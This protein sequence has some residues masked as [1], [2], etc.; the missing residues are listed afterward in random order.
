MYDKNAPVTCSTRLF[1]ICMVLGLLAVPFS[2]ACTWAVTPIVH[3][4][5]ATLSQSNS[6]DI[7]ALMQ[8]FLMS[9]MANTDDIS[10]A[11]S[12]G[13]FSQAWVNYLKMNQ[14]FGQYQSLLQQFNISQADYNAILSNMNLTDDQVRTIINNSQ[15]FQNSSMLYNTSLENGDE[16]NVSLYGSSI[17]NS[18]SNISSSYEAFRNNATA[19]E[20]ILGGRGM[21]TT[22]LNN[23]LNN[24]NGYL[25]NITSTYRDLGFG[26]NNAT[27][28]LNASKDLVS[29]G[30]SVQFTVYLTD[31]NNTPMSGSAVSLYL[32]GLP[33]G[34]VQTGA[35]GEGLL[36]CTIPANVSSDNI[37]A[38]AQYIPTTGAVSPA[39]SNIV[40]LNVTGMNT[41]LKLAM[42]PEIISYQAGAVVRGSLASVGGIPAPGK[43]IGFDIDGRYIG[44]ATTDDN[45][46]YAYSLAIDPG[47][48]AGQHIF[49]A[50]Y[51]PGPG[52][53]FL[54]SSGTKG[55][56]VT[57]LDTSLTLTPGSH[58]YSLCDQANVS[59]S[60]LTMGGTPVKGVNVSVLIDNITAGVFTTNDK[61][62]YAGSFAIPYDIAPGSHS[63]YAVF[64]PS[65][66]G[67]LFAS[68]AGPVFVNISDSG[69]MLIVSG[70]PPLLFRGEPLNLTG[71]MMTGKGVPVG[72]ENLSISLDGHPYMTV[73]TDSAGD[74]EMNAST[75]NAGPGIYTLTISDAGSGIVLY[76]GNAFLS[77]LSRFGT[78]GFV[79]LILVILAAIT[80]IIAMRFRRKREAAIIPVAI[81]PDAF[82]APSPEPLPEPFDLE[83]ELARIKAHALTGDL[84]AA[85]TGAYTAAKKIV[86]L[87][88]V[89]VRDWMTYFEFYSLAATELPSVSMPLRHIVNE[90]EKAVYSGEEVTIA[91]FDDTL[92]DL[93]RISRALG[94]EKR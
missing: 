63:F 21:D 7:N 17:V 41:I 15:L 88:G 3:V 48:T 18:Y 35:G 1:I 45:G 40:Y 83:K 69:H 64:R 27:L 59:G 50:V 10:S 19:L 67:S 90:Y 24:F 76:S 53:V 73:T 87:K 58:N 30:D 9:I 77:P 72:G 68:T 89:D 44:N 6:V 29:V 61:G 12:A 74:F 2:A 13:N 52:Q 31:Q 20:Q 43:T 4:D 80:A 46:M 34:S 28:Q 93:M 11:V 22:H 51:A 49:N 57:P 23:S 47:V 5:P 92:E 75:D 42:S 79:I 66:G 78:I 85:F 36:N 86:S 70:M 39:I 26:L 71:S 55:F 38:Y 65:A 14:N 84:K 37:S 94:E 32:D 8:S 81:S 82:I 91:E 54:G 56:N 33:A 62:A 60:L 25:G 16:T